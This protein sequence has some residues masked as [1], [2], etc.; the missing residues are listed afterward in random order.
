MRY[1]VL[2][3]GKR[4]R[5][6]LTLAAAE[7]AGGPRAEALVA[8][9]AV[10]LVHAFSLVHDDLPAL[11]NGAERR[12]RPTVHRAFGEAVAV[13][14]GDALL[15][16]AFEVLGSLAERP[17]VGPERA[18]SM[19]RELAVAAGS[20][21][22]VGGETADVLA[23]G[24]NVSPG[25]IAT[26]HAKKTARLFEAAARIGGRVGDVTPDLLDRLGLY[27]RTFGLAFQ[28]ADDLR[29]KAT[30]DTH[31]REPSLVRAVGVDRAQRAMR[32]QLDTART[33]ARSF[34]PQA[35]PFLLLADVVE[36][37]AR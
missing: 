28:I 9:A 32:R 15:A 14:A 36:D 21:G 31:A 20:H 30:D 37:R 35:G 18:A 3:G 8:G 34:G 24:E 2:G 12:G 25:R 13:L 11:D 5:P 26:I 4:V 10:E 22:L 6:Y 17:R 1:A 19:V 29:D 23:A 16:L 27:G 7:V 33:V